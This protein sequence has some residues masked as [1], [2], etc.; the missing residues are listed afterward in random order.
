MQTQA[1]KSKSD[2]D[3]VWTGIPE[4]GKRRK[5]IGIDPD[6]VSFL[7]CGGSWMGEKGTLGGI[8]AQLERGGA[9]G[10][11][12]NT[13]PYKD[14]QVGWGR[15]GETIGL[16]E[17]HRWLSTAWLALTQDSQRHLLAHCAPPPAEFRSDEGY[18]AR[19]TYVKGS[20]P[21][22]PRPIQPIGKRGKPIKQ[23]QFESQ[24]DRWQRTADR[25]SKSARRTSVDAELGEYATLAI[26]LCPTPDKLLLACSSPNKKNRE[27]RTKSVDVA[28]EAIAKA[29]AEWVESKEG[30]DPAR[31]RAQRVGGSK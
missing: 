18:G 5:L 25:L 1:K 28:K 19:D 15:T 27:L 6:L 4:A 30:A 9:G 12:P 26:L 7:V 29:H 17:K 10:G 31:T 13:D 11:M 24:L 23:K 3:R 21:V 2:S 20:H 16:V 8:I 22:G 14:A